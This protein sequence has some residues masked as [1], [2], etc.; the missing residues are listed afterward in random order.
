MSE[1]HIKIIIN[2]LY[3]VG[4][5]LYNFIWNLANKYTNN[6]LIIELERENNLTSKL[7]EQKQ[8]I[9]ELETE[10]TK[11][12]LEIEKQDVY[13]NELYNLYK[14]EKNNKAKKI[15]ELTNL[16]Y[17]CNKQQI[18]NSELISK[19]EGQKQINS[20]LIIEN[21]ILIKII[22]ELKTE[23]NK[24]KLDVKEKTQN[25]KCSICFE[26]DLNIC[27]IPCGHTYCDNCIKNSN[28]CYICRDTIIR[29]HKI[30]I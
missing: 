16:E 11:L 15:I 7:E 24:L 20:R 3:D 13:N 23:N 8:T 18:N 21:N 12:K 19:I 9:I 6:N 17:L 28:K 4:N 27:C 29:T 26:N 1:K 22:N 5:I 25:S 2:D 30:F 14:E 10:N